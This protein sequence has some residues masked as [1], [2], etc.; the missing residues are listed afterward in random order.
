MIYVW[1][2]NEACSNHAKED[3]L[4]KAEFKYEN[5]ETVLSNI[6]RCPICGKEMSYREE[7]RKGNG[8]NVSFTSFNSKSNEDKASMLKKRYRDNLKKENIS[9]VIKHKREQATKHFFGLD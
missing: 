1:C 2:N 7:L 8:I 6:P 5:G 9:E 3:I 4:V